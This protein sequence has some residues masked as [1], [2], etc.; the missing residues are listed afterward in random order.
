[1]P[2]LKEGRAAPFEPIPPSLD[3][4]ELVN[5][6]DNFKYV[7]RFPA[8]LLDDPDRFETV[9]RNWV[10]LGGEPMVIEG[11]Q[12]KLVPWL[13]SSGWLEQNFG[14]KGRH[15]WCTPLLHTFNTIQLQLPW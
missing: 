11:L 6:I 10:I 8:S 7:E 12:H 9:V 5:S 14:D 2:S 13:F 4:D 15:S 1:M 3:V